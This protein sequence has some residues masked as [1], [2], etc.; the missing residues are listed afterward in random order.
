M[1]FERITCA[2]VKIGDRIARAK[3]HTPVEVEAISE[4]QVSRRLIA[5]AGGTI[6]PRREAKLWRVVEP[7]QETE[8][9]KAAAT[10]LAESPEPVAE[11]VAAIEPAAGISAPVI[12]ALE[13]AWAEIQRRHPETPD[14][15]MITG[16]GTGRR[17]NALVRGHYQQDAWQLGEGKLPEVFISGE[18][19]ADGAEGVLATLLHEDAHAIAAVRGVQDTSRQGRYHNRRF[20]AIAEELG[21]KVEQDTRI[22]WSLT[23]LP[24]E[25]ALEYQVVLGELERALKLHR[26]LHLVPP[27]PGRQGPP[28]CVCACDRKIRVAPSVLEQAPITCG[29]CGE[30]FAPEEG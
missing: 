26:P 30:D 19:M 2:D 11:A 9:F 23:E 21:L 13:S 8:T 5:K 7:A 29:S 15:M 27:E 1:K 18:R 10:K 4:G 24:D 17:R 25:T 22:G 6:R 28:P 12:A 3:T 14:V 20:K 16:T